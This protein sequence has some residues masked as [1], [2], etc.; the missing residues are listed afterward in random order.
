MSQE[1]EEIKVEELNEDQIAKLLNEAKNMQPEA[2]YLLEIEKY[3]RED[4]YDRVKIVFGDAD[5]VPISKDER[6]EITTEII[7][8]K[9]DPVVVVKETEAYYSEYDGKIEVYVF[10]FDKGWIKVK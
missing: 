7:I 4:L 3:F 6:Q 2:K 5:I 8:P 10:T 9:T 1:K